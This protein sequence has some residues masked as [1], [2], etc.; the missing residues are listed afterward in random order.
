MVKQK[1]YFTDAKTKGV[2]QRIELNT[3]NVKKEYFKGTTLDT[4]GLSITAYY[5]DSYGT[6]ITNTVT[7]GYDTS[8]DFSST[9]Q[10]EVTVSYTKDGIT[11]TASYTVT[12]KDGY[13]VTVKHMQENLADSNYTLSEEE[14]FGVDIGASFTP[15]V[16]TYDDFNS[17]SVSSTTI[18]S[19]KTIELKYSRKTCMIT[20]RAMTTDASFIQYDNSYKTDIGNIAGVTKV[21]M[22]TLNDAYPPDLTITAKAG[23]DL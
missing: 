19:D 3:T 5:K 4:T 6:E 9:G 10:K 2:L 22:Q 7:A 18:N 1:G 17:P 12:V 15:T 13:K 20:Y 14:E 8:Y 11:K 16:K 23:T 21:T